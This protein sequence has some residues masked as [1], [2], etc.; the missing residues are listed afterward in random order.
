MS[1]RRWITIPIALALVTLGTS[2][3]AFAQTDEDHFQTFPFNFSNPGARSSAMGGAF[4]G[5]ADDASAAVANPAGLT[6]LTRRQVYFEYKSLDAP[7]V[8]LPNQNSLAG[9]F[10]S[11]VGTKRNLPSFINYA[12][13]VNDKITIAFSEHQFLSYKNDFNFEPRRTLGVSNEVFP[14]TSTSIE[15]TGFS[16][17]GAVGMVVSPKLRVGGA[18]SINR[19]GVDVDANRNVRPC[20]TCAIIPSTAIH[21]NSLAAGATA[22]LLYQASD[23][24]SLGVVYAYEPQFKVTESVTG[25]VAYP[26]FASD[27]SW[28]IPLRTPPRVGGGVGFRPNDR[29]LAA[30]DVAYVQ[31][32][33]LAEFTSEQLVLFRHFN[34]SFRNI[35]APMSVDTSQFQIKD[36]TDIHGGIEVNVLRGPNPVFIRYGASKTSPHTLRFGDQDACGTDIHSKEFGTTCSI[37]S[38][39]YFLSQSQKSAL[40]TADGENILL[41]KSE[42]GF[43]IG[44]GILIGRQTQIDVAY[45]RTNYLRKELTISSAI[46]F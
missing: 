28:Q 12:M 19:L 14:A 45:M 33:K 44:G 43:H 30:L 26:G 9:G 7:V 37:V 40:S 38:Q 35:T 36:G 42:I 27:T 10:G 6:N 8:V 15:M 24:L 11:L 23:A 39:L 46:R 3:P 20:P 16:F 31:Y 25:T 18:A 2:V 13:P 1:S 29:V 22:G 17:S 41:G 5:L 34:E 4:I 21:D 32:S